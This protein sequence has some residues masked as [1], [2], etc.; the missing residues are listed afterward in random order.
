[1]KKSILFGIWLFVS[2]LTACTDKTESGG[3][4][5]S[6]GGSSGYEGR[7]LPVVFHVLYED[8]TDAQQNPAQ[9]VFVRH[10]NRLNAF[11]AATLFGG[12]ASVAVNVSFKLAATDPQGNKMAEP[13]IHRVS[14]A[15][16]GSMDPVAFMDSKHPEGSANAGIFWDPNQYV[17]IWVFGF[18]SSQEE[19]DAGATVTGITHLPF[20]ASRYPLDGLVLDEKDVYQDYLPTYMHGMT[21]NNRFFSEEEGAFT[22][23]H[24]MGHYLGLFHAFADGQGDLCADVDDY[25]DDYCSDTP[26]YSR[27]EYMVLFNELNKPETTEEEWKQLEYRTSCS[28]VRF[29]STNVMDYYLG[30]RTSV[31][32]D[33]RDRIDFVLNHSPLIPRSELQFHCEHCDRNLKRTGDWK[34]RNRA[35][36]AE[37]RCGECERK[38]TGRIQC[39]LK[40]EG[41]VIKKKLTEKVTEE[42]TAAAEEVPEADSVS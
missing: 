6:S 42:K 25:G 13:G 26:K 14:Y 15:G 8:A 11:Y 20:A 24:E 9:S 40:Y 27:P 22:L 19:A 16:A 3:S 7:P 33:Q 36:F 34:F 32:A 18:K 17:N 37:F 41:V 5:G 38:Y 29:R 1:M 39:K 4:G 21:L 31:T 12:G 10:I 30:D 28:G 35:F 23:W 2:C